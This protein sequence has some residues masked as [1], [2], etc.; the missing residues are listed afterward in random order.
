MENNDSNSSYHIARAGKAL[1]IFTKEQIIQGLKKGTYQYSDHIWDPKNKEA[2]WRKVS[3]LFSD[4]STGNATPPLP[5]KS[6]RPRQWYDGVSI[7]GDS[8]LGDAYFWEFLLKRAR[9]LFAA[10]VMLVGSVMFAYALTMDPD[11]SAIRQAVIQQMQTNGLLVIL[12]GVLI[13]KR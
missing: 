3:D 2:G 8:I 6:S 1:G 12:I 9:P 7:H 4:S 10:L 5:P 11:N 13:A